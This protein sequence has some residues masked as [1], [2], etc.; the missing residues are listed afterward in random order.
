MDDKPVQRPAIVKPGLYYGYIIVLATFCINLI[1]FGIRITYGIFFNPIASEFGWDSASLSSVFSLSILVEGTFGMILGKLNDRFGPRPVLI[2]TGIFLGAGYFFMSRVNGLWQMYLF[3]GILVGIGMGGTIVPVLTTI[4]RWFVSRRAIMAGVVLSGGGIGA[5]ILSPLSEWIIS[6]YSWQTAYF[7]M[8]IVVFIMVIVAAMF[9]KKD[10]AAV[11]L[12]PYLK[13][14]SAKQK[15]IPDDA[16]FSL[17]KAVRTNQF[18]LMGFVFIVYGYV[19]Y[20]V[21]VHLVPHTISVGTDPAVAAG[22]IATFGI[23]GIPGRIFLGGM[24]DRIGNKRVYM[25]CYAIFSLTLVAL[26]AVRETWF[27]YIA[28]ALFGVSSGGIMSIAAALTVDLFGLKSH[29]EIFGTLGFINTIGGA[30]GPFIAG[31]IFDVT[32]GYFTA[33]L[34][35]AVAGVLAVMSILMIKPVTA[36]AEVHNT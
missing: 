3:Y 29:G 22:F 18:W 1:V 31:Y 25:V 21:V 28:S 26:L 32:A 6:S 30:L 34:I 15:S 8:S 20:S 4:S 2:L 11:G 7:V 5:L 14:A 19:G 27:F 10:P 17:K 23:A 12:M 9:L 35:C 24:A 16:S 33:F 36:K 13:S